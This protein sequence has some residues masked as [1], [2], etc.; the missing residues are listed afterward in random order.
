MLSSDMPEEEELDGQTGSS[1]SGS[2]YS[3]CR[4]A[5]FPA[6][7]TIPVDSSVPPELRTRFP[8]GALQFVKD[9]ERIAV[10]LA[11]AER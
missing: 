10:L 2:I 3:A 6:T 4:I 9:G 7:I 8:G 11:E 5:D 1:T